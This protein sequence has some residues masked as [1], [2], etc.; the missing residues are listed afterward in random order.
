MK[1]TGCG[2]NFRH[3]ADFKAERPTGAS[4]HIIM[5]IRSP[6]RIT[7]DGKDHFVSG[8]TVIVYRKRSP[9][10][11][12][13][14]NGPFI[15]DWIRFQTDARELAQ[16]EGMGIR[17][18]TLT[19]YPDIYDLSHLVKMLS[20][21]YRSTNKNAQDT[22]V[23]LMQVL[24]LKLSDRMTKKPRSHGQLTEKLN[25]LRN[26]IYSAPQNDWTIDS[27][28]QSLSI[29]PSYLQHKYKEQFGNTIKN[30]ITASRL[31]FGKYLLST[32][33][34]SVRDISQ[35]IGYENDV[36]FMYMFKKKTGMTPSEYRHAAT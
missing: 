26:N 21:E 19:E 36:H 16:L 20:M 12:G 23:A 27:I 4:G 25:D 2:Y 29:S 24:F 11:Y 8:N 33:D 34:H 3:D 18:D 32:T 30:D 5:I 1:I 9:H 28:C 14:H 17:F 22:M 7:L 6:A 15:N 10:I 35:M 31:E 13:A